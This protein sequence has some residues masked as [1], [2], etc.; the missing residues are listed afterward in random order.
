ME[1]NTD[2]RLG[3]KY[4]KFYY[5]LEQISELAGVPTNTIRQHIFRGIVNPEQFSSVFFYIE[6]KRS[7]QGLGF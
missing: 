4:K 3:R 7:E 2:N 6:S 1:E 5:T